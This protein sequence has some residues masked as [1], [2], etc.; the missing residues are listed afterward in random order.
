MTSQEYERMEKIYNYVYSAPPGSPE[1]EARQAELN[2]DDRAALWDY[3]SGLCSGRIK[4]PEIKNKESKELGGLTMNYQQWKAL[5][6]SSAVKNQIAVSKFERQNP[7]TAS[8]YKKRLEDEK[9][10]RSEIMAIEDTRKRHEEIAKN[11]Q[12]F[13]RGITL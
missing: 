10:K 12:L 4:R 2:M 6:K 9:K 11:M 8:E 5:S 13:E 7:M 1:R 3:Y